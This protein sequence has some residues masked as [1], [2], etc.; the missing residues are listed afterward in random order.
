MKTFGLA[1]LAAISGYII[2]LF[3]G[4]FF[5]EIFSTNRHDKSLEAAMMGA[6]VLGPL[7]AV[8]AVIVVLISRHRHAR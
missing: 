1:V 4:M 6:F 2:G 7:M 3:G 8:A 5:I